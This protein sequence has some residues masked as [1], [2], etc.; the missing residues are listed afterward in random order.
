[1]FVGVDLLYQF[2]G[3]FLQCVDLFKV[4]VVVVLAVIAAVVASVG[5]GGHKL[6]G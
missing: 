6:F 2:D 4:V 3:V 5:G 1:M